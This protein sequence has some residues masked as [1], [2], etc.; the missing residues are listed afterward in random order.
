MFNNRFLLIIVLLLFCISVNLKKH[1]CSQF[2]HMSDMAFCCLHLA[3]ILSYGSIQ[4]KRLTN[5]L[6][7]KY[8]TKTIIIKLNSKLRAD[9]I[10]LRFTKLVNAFS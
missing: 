4:V 3:V 10:E 9:V 5:S 1:T 7:L 6:S 2:R 8:A